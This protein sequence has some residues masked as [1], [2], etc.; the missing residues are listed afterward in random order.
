MI[1]RVT[2]HHH[3]A[4]VQLRRKRAVKLAET[5]PIHLETTHPPT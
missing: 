3:I 4:N 1:K 5:I 2:N